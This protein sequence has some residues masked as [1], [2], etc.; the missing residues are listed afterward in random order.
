MNDALKTGNC[1]IIPNAKVFKLKTDGNNAVV[2]AHYYLDG[3]EQV[4]E[5]STFVVACQA[6]ETSRLLLASKNDD[7][8]NLITN[9]E[10][11]NNQNE[12]NDKNFFDDIVDTPNSLYDNNKLIKLNT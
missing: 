6:I 3:E 9:T 1:E 5:A 8:P 12:Q 4:V 7:T 2:S 10:Q 11:K